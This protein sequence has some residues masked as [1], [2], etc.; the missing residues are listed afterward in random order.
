MSEFDAKDA[1]RKQALRHS[2]RQE[3]EIEAREK[4]EKELLSLNVS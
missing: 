3:K 4:N 1:E 2:D